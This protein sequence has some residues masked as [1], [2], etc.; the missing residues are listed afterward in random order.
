MKKLASI[1]LFAILLY[2][3]GG[4]AVAF[5]LV[6]NEWKQS[7]RE[8]LYSLAGEENWVVFKVATKDFG[9]EDE[10]IHDG[11]YYDIVKF[12]N[13]GDSVLLRCFDDERETILAAAYDN[14]ISQNISQKTDYQGKTHLIFNKIIKE[15]LFEIEDLGKSTPSVKTAFLLKIERQNR[16]FIAPFL[17]A[18]SPPPK[19]ILI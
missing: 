5:R 8:Q 1:F 12:E 10:I 6:Q 4:Y 7:V 16:I 13:Q 15:F 18:E 2:N 3:L 19:F 14:Q 9:G 11:K 17:S